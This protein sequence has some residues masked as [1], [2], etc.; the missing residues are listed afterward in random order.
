VKT[1]SSPRARAPARPRPCA[2]W[3][4]PRPAAE[5]VAFNKSIAEEARR[6]FSASVTARTAHSFAW[7]W[8]RDNQHAAAVLGRLE[9]RVPW[10]L[11]ADALDVEPMRLPTLNQPGHTFQR[12]TVTRWVLDM[13]R[14]FC[15][16][17]AQVLGVEHMPTVPG[18]TE[19]VRDGVAARLLPKASAAWAE[20]VNPSG[21]F[22]QVGHDTYL[23]L[24]QL[25]KP[26]LPGEYLLFDEAQDASPVVAAVVAAQPGQ[27]AYVGDESQAI[28][29]WGAHATPCGPSTPH[30]GSPCPSPGGSETGSQTGQT[31]SSKAR[32]M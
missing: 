30:T 10:T 18:L 25:A 7:Q 20:L 3:P 15:Q 13:V 22:C 12:A 17:D 26:V 19:E 8:A 11:T 4:P 2:S 27:R 31:L 29:G 21:S 23:K 5:Y 16:S 1:W 32:R 24:W 6:S 28:Y 9:K 14:L